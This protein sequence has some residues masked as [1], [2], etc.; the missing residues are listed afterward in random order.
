[1]GAE[2]VKKKKKKF[3]GGRGR[4][5]SSGNSELDGGV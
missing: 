5:M 4:K 2:A 1:M 3:R